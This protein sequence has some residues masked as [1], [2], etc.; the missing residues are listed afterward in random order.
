MIVVRRELDVLLRREA[1]F[2]LLSAILDFVTSPHKHVQLPSCLAS[3]SDIRN[4]CKMNVGYC[5]GLRQ[6][7]TYARPIAQQSPG[8]GLEC[9][10][11]VVV[12]VGSNR[13]R[14]ARAAAQRGPGIA[15]GN[16]SGMFGVRRNVWNVTYARMDC[17]LCK[18]HCTT[19]SR[20]SH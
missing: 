11:W 12:C 19:E 18:T 15:L 8:I 4:A 3:G 17:E 13:M 16:L 20:K 2:P 7:V 1:S 10:Q 9:V 14:H 5:L 6:N